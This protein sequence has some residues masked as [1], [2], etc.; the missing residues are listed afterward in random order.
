[1]LIQPVLVLQILLPGFSAVQEVTQ[2]PIQLELALPTPLLD[3]SVV[4]EATHLVEQLLILLLGFLVVL[5]VI[6]M[7][8]L[9]LPLYVCHKTSV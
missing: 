6:R 1:M 8:M 3:C 5:G 4:Q 2:K 7:P 9:L